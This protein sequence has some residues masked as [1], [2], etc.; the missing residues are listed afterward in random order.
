MP[1]GLEREIVDQHFYDQAVARLRDARVHLPKLSELA[2]P[3]TL[4][5]S[6]RRSLADVGPDEPDARNLYR[7]HWHNAADR[8]GFADTPEHVA[9]PKSL[10]G[11]DAR[12]VV[13]LGNRFPMVRCHKVLAAYGCLVPRLV[14]GQ[15]DPSRQRAVWPSTG[16]YCRGGVAISR[17]LGCRS[18]AVLPEG[19]SRERFAWLEHWVSD[20]ADIVRTPGTESNVKEIYDACHELAE[21]PNNVIFNQFNEFGNY[22]IHRAVTGPAME[23]V[24]HAVNSAKNLICRAYVSAS[25]SAGT[26]AAGDYLKERLGSAVCVVEALECPTL[27]YNGYGEHN[28]QGIGDKHVPFI[29]NVM[30]TDYAIGVSDQ[31]SDALNLLFNT[32][33]GRD[34]LGSRRRIDQQMLGSLADLG[35]SS[36]ANVLAAIKLAK[37]LDLGS[38]DVILTVA[39]DGAEMYG[40][41]LTKAQEKYFAGGFDELAAAETIGRFLLGAATD[42]VLELDRRDRERMFNLG[43]YTWVEQQGVSV[44]DFDA[45]RSPSFWNGLM[46]MVPIWDAAIDEFNTRTASPD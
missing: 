31:A 35:I 5:E 4:Q 21:D 16:N 20:R 36:I 9:L 45:R 34:V 38:D 25:G 15:F 1:I 41:E 8:H 23:R 10:T 13:A 22:I 37:Y 43:Y 44:A 42:H 26:L 27:L 3:A 12:I 2:E 14:T 29:H 28:I 24:F 7:V 46:E 19:M 33:T 18:V 17:I 39:T 30:N 6:Y 32:T 40:T 11:V